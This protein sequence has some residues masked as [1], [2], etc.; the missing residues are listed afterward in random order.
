[1][2]FFWK[3]LQELLF[4]RFCVGCGRIFTFLC[5]NC[6]EDID[7]FT[8]PLSVKL[9]PNY[10]NNLLACANYS[11]PISNL[12]KELKY[13]KIKGLSQ[14]C[15]HIMYYSMN[16]PGTDFITSVPLHPKR[17]QERGFNQAQ[18][19]AMELSLLLNIPYVETL[20]RTRHTINQA[21]LHDKE[22]RLVNLKN[23]FELNKNVSLQLM[24]NKSIIIIDDVTTTGTTLNECAKVLKQSGA[25]TVIGVTLAHG[26]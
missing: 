12:I 1:M 3:I 19:I 2:R 9:E 15:A 22:K 14:V 20:K 18:E 24:K 11:S 21:S 4:P 17:Q 16:I 25:K 23:I 7:F 6:Y 8:L 10:L 13:N 5:T 26:S